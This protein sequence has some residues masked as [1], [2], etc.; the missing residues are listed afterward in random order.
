M[1]GL[2]LGHRE[3]LLELLR[4]VPGTGETRMTGDEPTEQIDTLILNGAFEPDQVEVDVAGGSAVARCQKDPGKESE[5]EDT[6]AII[7]YGPGSRRRGRRAAGRQTGV[8][9]RRYDARHGLA[10]GDG[11]DHVAAHG[12]PQR[13]R[14]GQ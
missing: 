1:Q 10:D 5:N 8:A 3:R 2:Q 13:D 6:A 14:S 12:H 4:L 11:Q 9:D 7:P